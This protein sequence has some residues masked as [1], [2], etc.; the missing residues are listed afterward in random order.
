[1]RLKG[2][3]VGCGVLLLV[4][5]GFTPYG[6]PFLPGATFSDA[7]TSHWGA[8]LFT[9]ETV[10]SGEYPLWRETILGGMPF[11]ANPLN[12]TAYPLQWLVLILP[13]TVHLN[14]MIVLHVALAGVGMWQWARV[15]DI[16]EEG[17]ALAVLAYMLSPRLVAHLGAG[18]LDIVY[19]LGWLPWLMWLLHR[20][21]RDEGATL[22]TLKL[23]LVA[24][25]VL[26]AD[27]RVSLFG[28]AF[29]A[30][31][32]LWR[33]AVDRD[34]MRIGWSAVAVVPFLLLVAGGLVPLLGWQ[35]YLSRSL[36]TAAE[37]GALSVQP[38]GLT[39]LLLPPH[40]AGNNILETMV[41][42]GN[43]DTGFG[44]DWAAD[45]AAPADVVLAGCG[46]LLRVVG[47]GDERAI[48]ERVGNV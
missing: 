31:Y 45:A 1:M 20:G 22:Y 19:A 21:T 39:G 44:G 47:L 11:A 48:V 24:G 36:L 15:H 2:L 41:Y 42:V 23:A 10:L 12:K 40:E 6:L 5:A 7:V 13:A 4:I 29:G 27:V 3:V 18:H 25:M 26:L 34:V 43:A 33:A 46:G 14:V 17:A 37:A 32:V 38:V 16:R 9:R 30:A 35:P 8:A 28:F